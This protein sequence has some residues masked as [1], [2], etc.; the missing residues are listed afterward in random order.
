MYSTVVFKD[1]NQVKNAIK[2]SVLRLMA[3]LQEKWCIYFRIW[4]KL[5]KNFPPSKPVN[6]HHLTPN[7][8]SYKLPVTS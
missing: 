7:V 2:Y 6:Q 3:L 8:I 5:Y 1:I 4:N